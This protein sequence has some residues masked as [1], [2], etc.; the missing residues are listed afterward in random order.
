M[1][2]DQYHVAMVRTRVRILG[3]DERFAEGFLPKLE[4][5]LNAQEVFESSQ[6]SARRYLT[7]DGENWNVEVQP[8]SFDVEAV[9]F[10]DSGDL[11]EGVSFFLGQLREVAQE[12]NEHVHFWGGRVEA[13]AQWVMDAKTRRGRTVGAVIN[14]RAMKLRPIQVDHLPGEVLGAGITLVARTDSCVYMVE[15]GPVGTDTLQPSV[16]V[17][18]PEPEPSDWPENDIEAV[19]QNIQSAYDL[20]EN[21]VKAFIDAVML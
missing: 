9:G 13:T 2:P 3:F 21:D 11:Q 19:T 5:A 16:S 14:A 8:G 1:T 10:R 12:Y 4:A 17:T 18:F 6:A 7:L 15:L 20:L